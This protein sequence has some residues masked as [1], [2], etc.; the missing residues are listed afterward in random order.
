MMSQIALKFSAL[1]RYAGRHGNAMAL[2]AVLG[3]SAAMVAPVHADGTKIGFVSTERI[4]RDSKPAKA[5]Q[6]KIEAEFKDRDAKLKKMAA[7]LLAQDKKPDKDA[8]VHS[9][10]E[11]TQ[12]RKH[13][14]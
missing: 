2:A 10:Y 12:K 13:A 7:D 6:A 8:P 3:L 11:R 5:A 14:G 9:Q 4:L 1:T